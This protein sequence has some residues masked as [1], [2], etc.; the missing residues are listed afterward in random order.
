[1]EATARQNYWPLARSG[2]HHPVAGEGRFGE[3]AGHNVAV[4]RRK[5]NLER[6]IVSFA[7]AAGVTLIVLGVMWSRTGRDALHYPDEIESV[8]PAPGDKQVL[9]ETQVQVQ[10]IAGYGANLTIDGI[11]LEKTDLDDYLQGVGQ[12][13]P[14]EQITL[15]STAIFDLANATITFQPSDEA[16]ITE[17]KQG[18]HN[19]TVTF[20]KLTE[21]EETAK[22]FSWQFE[23][24]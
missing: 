19:A 3:A 5:I 14:G 20:W 23:V 17:F 2:Q 6:L 8:S 21:G 1:L 24:L 13:A 16:Q 22:V 9:R 10:L 4:P 18:I 11:A 7:F 15:P 12:P